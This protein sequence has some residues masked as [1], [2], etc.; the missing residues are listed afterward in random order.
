VSTYGARSPSGTEALEFEGAPAT[1]RRPH[2]FALEAQALPLSANDSQTIAAETEIMLL[3]TPGAEELLD[4]R[5]PRG[6]M[7]VG[8][9]FVI[10]GVG[11]SRAPLFLVRVLSVTELRGMRFDL[12]TARLEQP[13]EDVSSGPRAANERPATLGDQAARPRPNPFAATDPRLRARSPSPELPEFA[14]RACANTIEVG[15]LSSIGTHVSVTLLA[16]VRVGERLVLAAPRDEIPAGVFLALRYFDSTGARRGIM[17][18][19]AVHSRPG[20]LDEVEGVLICPPTRA[21]ERQSYRAPFDDLVTIELTGRGG[22]T[23]VAQLLDLSADGIGFRVN[24]DLEPDDRIRI[25]DHDLGGL[26]GAELVIVRRD[27]RDPPRYGAR[28]AEKN[29][30]ATTLLVRLDLDEAERARRRRAQIEEIRRALDASAG[31]LSS[32]DVRS[33][34]NGR[35]GTRSHR[36]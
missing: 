11:S 24:A 7:S 14:L 28:F 12:V 16:P 36:F 2:V 27:A 1:A 8:M 34:P 30:G 19:E 32:A 3:M 21:P 5:A 6:T 9:R 23:A 17:R 33:L 22:R 13:P 4:L 15:G 10:R 20:M 18:V 31:P 35:M 25:A 29:R 26:D